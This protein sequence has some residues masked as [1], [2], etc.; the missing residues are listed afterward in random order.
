M[1]TFLVQ[2]LATSLARESILYDILKKNNLLTEDDAIRL[3]AIIPPEVK[4]EFDPP[5]N[6]LVMPYFDRFKKM[7]RKISDEQE[8]NI[9]E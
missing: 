4:I 6:D 7:L 5:S 1:F 9:S 8:K 2:E 3:A